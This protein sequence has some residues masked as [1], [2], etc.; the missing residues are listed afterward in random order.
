MNVRMIVRCAAVVGVAVWIAS[1]TMAQHSNR[2]L[3]HA[4]PSRLLASPETCTTP[5]WPGEARR[6]EVEGM[7]VLHFQIGEDGS[8]EGAR[9]AKTSSWKLLDEA[10]LQSLVKCRFRS[11]M[12][13]AER[14]KTFPVQFVWSFAGP[15]S[16][17]PQLVPG[18]CAASA[19]YAKF[20]PY[21]RNA[22]AH[23]GVLLRFL[24]NAR[25]E[26]F[27]VKA[28]AYGEYVAAGQAAAEYV[29][30][31]RFAVDPETPGEKTDTVFGRVLVNAN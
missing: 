13:E 12:A 7:T 14:G 29:K 25:G 20:Q 27:G 10:A 18:S 8:V 30:T 11:G 16:V 6:Y 2:V 1:A 31:C 28:E 23:D 4:F 9:V 17:R 15:P 3:A 5:E 19:R 21:N 22:T 26:P 24:V